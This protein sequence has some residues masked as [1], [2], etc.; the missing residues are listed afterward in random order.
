MVKSMYAAI[1]GLRTHQSKMDVISNNIANVNTWGY[2]SRSANFQDAMY[3]NLVNSTGGNTAN[4][5]S[6]GV[7]ASQV[8]YG[9]NMGSISTNFATGSW[10]YTGRSLDCMINGTGFFIVGPMKEGDI[11][12]DDISD[13]GLSLSKVGIFSVDNNGYLVDG[14]GNYVYGFA[15]DGE[16]Y[17]TSKLE[18]I[19]VPGDPSEIATYTIKKDGTVSCVTTEDETITIGQIAVASVSNPNGL[20]QSSGYLYEIGEN[21][22]SVAGIP[23]TA[24]TGDI[25][26][27][28]LEMSNVDLSTDMANMITTQ[29]GYQAN[30]KIITVT[31]EMLEQLVNMKR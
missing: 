5:G 11:S 19:K 1:A 7:N 6:G 2:K 31:D 22:G 25:L 14:D 15:P 27:N 20:S 8:G 12:A 17:D 29:R 16:G 13:S 30:T 24:A 4:G 9:V 26:S 10:G 21:A 18:P 23:T 3:Q 28:Y